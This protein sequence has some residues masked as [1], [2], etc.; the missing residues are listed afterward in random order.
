MLCNISNR[1]LGFQVNFFLELFFHSL[2]FFIKS[3]LHFS[4]ILNSSREKKYMLE[5]HNWTSTGIYLTL[6][7]CVKICKVIYIV[8]HL[9]CAI[10]Q[11]VL[12]TKYLYIVLNL[13]KLQLHLYYVYSVHQLARRIYLN[14]NALCTVHTR[15]FSYAAHYF[16]RWQQPSSCKMCTHIASWIRARL[17][18]KLCPCPASKT[19]Y[20]KTLHRCTMGM[21]STVAVVIKLSLDLV[22]PS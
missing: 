21:D 5:K 11:N 14:L 18:C 16:C 6:S 3:L 9:I 10:H 22:I 17:N 13:A 20:Y 4:K 19:I 7:F 8:C 1:Y 2:N 15:H 12:N